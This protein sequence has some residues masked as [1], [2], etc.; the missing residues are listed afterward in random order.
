MNS[1]KHIHIYCV[2][3]LIA[4]IDSNINLIIY[5][6]VNNTERISCIITVRKYCRADC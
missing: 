5:S 6:N 4:K 2:H 1:L 3:Y